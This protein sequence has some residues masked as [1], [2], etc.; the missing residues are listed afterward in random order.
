[1]GS[2]FYVT[3]SPRGRLTRWGQFDPTHPNLETEVLVTEFAKWAGKQPEGYQR[4]KD[5][6]DFWVG[7]ARAPA[8]AAA[9]CRLLGDAYADWKENSAGAQWEAVL[10]QYQPQIEN[11]RTAATIVAS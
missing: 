2:H 11:L 7:P 10:A 5:G 9:I 6:D 4:L 3:L 1:M 8:N